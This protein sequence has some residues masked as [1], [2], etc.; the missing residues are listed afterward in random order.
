MALFLCLRDAN[1]ALRR[2]LARD[3][4]ALPPPEYVLQ[5]GPPMPVLETREVAPGEAADARRDPALVAMARAM[6]TRVIAPQPLDH[7]RPDDLVP[8]WG[9][10]AIGAGSAA[11][12]LGQIRLAILDTGI[13]T[14][15][16]AFDGV[17]LTTRDFVGTG[18]TD[19]HG[20]GTQLA[21]I[22]VGGDRDVGAAT[23]IATALVGK[24]L[25]DDGRG[26]SD[27]LAA[28]LIWAAEARADVIAL[29]L[30][31]DPDRLWTRLAQ[32]DGWP[33]T[34]A[35]AAA[36]EAYRDTETLLRHLLRMVQADTSGGPLIV[37]AVGNDSLRMVAPDYSVGPGLPAGLPG[38]VAVGAVGQAEDRIEVAPFSNTN[39]SFCAPGVGIVTADLGHATRALNDS[40]A[41]CAYAAATAARWTAHLRRMGPACA[42]DTRRAMLRSCVTAAFVPGQR[43][44]ERGHGLVQAPPG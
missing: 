43:I 35:R 39:P 18:V 10:G 19:M 31:L 12:G 37:A 9:L 44:A 30:D 4:L 7:L 17:T 23:G 38:I 29:A 34:L 3:G 40:S 6:P 16:P 25:A 42:D 33:E 13:E 22:S 21:G 36:F 11:D 20:H 27:H 15:H 28:G 2:A 32:R 26:R 5:H 8:G 1:T 24:V 14:D 41:A